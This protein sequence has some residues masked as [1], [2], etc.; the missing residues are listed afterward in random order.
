ME[1]LYYKDAYL[2]QYES[3]VT[4]VSSD[5]KYTYVKLESPL[6]YPEGGGQCGDR[7]H[8]NSFKVLD[9]KKAPDGNSVY[10]LEKEAEGKIK[11]KETVTQTLDWDHRYEFM[12]KHTA[13][14]L[15]SGLLFNLFKI[16]TVA[17]HL[18]EE[19][20]TIETD[21][22]KIDSG[23]VKKLVLEANR[24]IW[25]SHGIKSF[26][27]SHKE[28][29]E[30]NLRRSIKVEGT[31][32]IVEIE[33][34]DRIACGGVH[35]RRTSEIGLITA[36]GHEQIRGHE[37]ICF[38]CAEKALELA[39][40]A[41]NQ[42]GKLC[43]L[44]S[45]RT[46]ETAQKV[47]SLQ[48][49]LTRTKAALGLS[50]IKNAEAEFNEKREGSLAIIDTDL[51]VD[52]FRPLSDKEEPLALCA[53]KTEGDRSSWIIILKGYQLDIKSLLS[54]TSARGGGREP[55]YQGV[56]ETAKKEEFKKLF[57]ESVS[58]KS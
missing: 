38:N 14:H 20:L 36:I 37:R 46:E 50:E 41:E 33:G 8:L 6:F 21:R 9:T 10:Y 3:T 31:V 32:R 34:L 40:K 57:K 44:L 51:S 16:G 22:E 45:C 28:A 2:K 53:I 13:Q 23:T 5:D 48:T 43:A 4:E 25:E 19:Y 15:L 11:V 18:G 52:R 35:V 56:I 12:K 30:L 17:V 39:L 58:Q 1:K 26:E 7:G 47:A 24:A 49:E 29:E 27:V 42:D 54:Q 55:V